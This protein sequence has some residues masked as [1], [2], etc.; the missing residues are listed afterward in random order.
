MIFCASQ[1]G[2]AETRRSKTPR[3]GIGCVIVLKEA[4]TGW[5]VLASVFVLHGIIL[6]KVA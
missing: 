5:R 3:V 1:T 4:M 2:A 6:L